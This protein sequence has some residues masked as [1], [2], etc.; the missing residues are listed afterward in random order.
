MEAAE[1][2]REAAAGASPTASYA[3]A[4]AGFEHERVAAHL[5]GA[6]DALRTAAVAP[7][8]CAATA[9]RLR[10]LGRA[11]CARKRAWIWKRW[12]AI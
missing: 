4:N 12:N 6:A 9:E 2:L 5:E 10:E 1:E 3:A 7:E 8:A 11:R